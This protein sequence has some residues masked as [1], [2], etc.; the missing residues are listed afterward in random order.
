MRK[1]SFSKNQ[2]VAKA[3][4]T[5]SHSVMKRILAVLVALPLV[6]ALSSC[7]RMKMEFKVQENMFGEITFDVGLDKELMSQ[8]GKTTDD[9]CKEFKQGASA[10]SPGAATVKEYDDGK[11]VGCKLSGSGLMTAGSDSPFKKVGDEIHFKLNSD[12]LDMDSD[13]LKSMGGA[14]NIKNYL[15][16]FSVSVTFPGEVLTHSGSSTVSGTTVTWT[17]PAELYS[18]QGL[19]ATAKASGANPMGVVPGSN[20]SADH[21]DDHKTY[22]GDDHKTSGLTSDEK[23]DGDSST[24][25]SGM[26]GWVVPTI[27]VAVVAVVAGVVFWLVSAKRKRNQQKIMQAGQANPGQPYAPYPQDGQDYQQPGYG[28]Q[29][30]QPPYP[31]Q[32]YF[33]PTQSGSPNQPGQPGQFYGG[34][35][36]YDAQFSQP[37][38][39]V[40]PNQPYSQYGYGQPGQF[41]DPTGQMGAPNGNQP[42]PTQGYVGQPGQP[43]VNP[44]WQPPTPDGQNGQS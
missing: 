9:F 5:S 41:G 26:P 6:V 4:S 35:P 34:Q 43:E 20:K 33:D 7:M 17:D 44:D 8:S 28:Q 21:S 36:G 14:G 42:Y 24:V 1:I 3:E 32:G 15:T 2:Q 18:A 30:A 37:G 38:Q 29:Y 19:S 27:I 16:D 23:S 13:E 39:P 12:S 31:G 22:N 11:Y 10:T 40:Q 25:K